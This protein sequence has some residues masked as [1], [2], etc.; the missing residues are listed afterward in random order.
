MKIDI[1]KLNT[2]LKK[3]KMT[4][5]NFIGEAVFE[6]SKDGLH[7]LAT[8]LPK[9]VQV[10]A[11]LKPTAF[12]EYEAIGNIGL[13]EIDKLIKVLGRFSGE[14]A[15]STTGNLMKVKGTG[16][17]VD[18]ELID[19]SII[20]KTTAIAELDYKDKFTLSPSLLVDLSNDLN[21]NPNVQFTFKTEK[22]KVI[23]TNKGKYKFTHEIESDACEGG[24][25]C[26]FGS[27]FLDAT[28]EL[29]DVVEIKIGDGLPCLITEKTDESE[30]KIIVA[31]LVDNVD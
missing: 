3:V 6:F 7:I 22:D 23:M 10:D 18:I 2:F 16:K 19:E 1:K 24:V 26:N 4:N 20:E 14:V 28:N 30:I 8:S 25:E 9:L 15:I 13:N 17:S 11:I 31:P 27:P 29:D 21:M 12:K 5:E